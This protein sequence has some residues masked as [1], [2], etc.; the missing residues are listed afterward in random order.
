MASISSL[1]KEQLLVVLESVPQSY[2]PPRPTRQTKETLVSIIQSAHYAHEKV[3][4]ALA[5]AWA[6]RRMD[7]LRTGKPELARLERRL[8]RLSDEIAKR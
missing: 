3:R 8:S 4:Q 2:W 6:E 5:Q 1:T 7:N